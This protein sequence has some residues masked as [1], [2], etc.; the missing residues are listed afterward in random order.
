LNKKPSKPTGT[1]AVLSVSSTGAEIKK[2][3]FPKTKDAIEEFIVKTFIKNSSRMPLK[4]TDVF[5]NNENDFDFT[6]KTEEGTKYLELMEIAPLENLRGSYAQ[7]PDHYKPYDFARY[8]VEKIF[9][10]S[11]RYKSS[12]SS[13]TNICLLIYVTDWAFVPSESVIHLLQY[14]T[15]NVPHSFQYICCYLPFDQFSGPVELIYPIKNSWKD[16]D[17]E[18]YKEKEVLNLSPLKWE[19]VK[20]NNA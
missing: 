12:P 10:K 2:L 6:I 20:H 7:A 1:M 11:K 5:Q 15:A 14:W 9:G 16:F 19:V 3:E 18:Q 13:N 4:I 17:P 8:I